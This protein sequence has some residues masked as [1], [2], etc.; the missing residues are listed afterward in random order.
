MFRTYNFPLLMIAMVLTACSHGKSSDALQNAFAE[1]GNA[2]LCLQRI[3]DLAEPVYDVAVL[4]DTAMQPSKVYLDSLYLNGYAFHE[5]SSVDL[6]KAGVGEQTITIDKQVYHLLYANAVSDFTTY[7]KIV[8]DGGVIAYD[9][10]DSPV[11]DLPLNDFRTIKFGGGGIVNDVQPNK[12]LEM[13]KVEP[14]FKYPADLNLE[15]NQYNYNG[16]DLFVV[17]NLSDEEVTFRGRFGTLAGA[18]EMWDPETKQ[19]FAIEDYW[20]VR[21]A[22]TFDIKQEP[23]QTLIYVFG[24]NANRDKMKEYKL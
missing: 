4:L 21:G 15:W 16:I 24:T 23:G 12:V 8:S 13:M 2:D 11:K 18:P 3:S 6:A 10:P 17:R 14:Q 5:I 9:V 19:Q 22:V 20:Q 1:D 7:K